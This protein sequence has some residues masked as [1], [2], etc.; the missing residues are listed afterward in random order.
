M[1]PARRG[2]AHGVRAD[3]AGGWGGSSV[4]VPMRARPLIRRPAAAAVLRL[5]RALACTLPLA[6]VL[7]GGCT[8]AFSTNN[9]SG[10]DN[11]DGTT[12]VVTS[13]GAGGMTS[14]DSAGGTTLVASAELADLDHR[15]FELGDICFDGATPDEYAADFAAVGSA[16]LP[17]RRAAACLGPDAVPW[18]AS[19]A[20]IWPPDRIG[21]AELAAFAGA[22][23]R[24]N[25][26]RLGLPLPVAQLQYLETRVE[27]GAATVRFG[28]RA[29]DGAPAVAV[30]YA[31]TG[32]VFAIERL[33][34]DRNPNLR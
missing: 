19:A 27:D 10:D 5:A 34:G 13:D 24:V 8:W 4:T 3:L 21:E 2:P 28:D 14:N 15:L 16:P 7:G 32:E 17:Y 26:E 30:E 11:N 31:T 12:V 22:V 6:W 23:L 9:H 1:R 25:E 20:R 33:D 18:S 29:A